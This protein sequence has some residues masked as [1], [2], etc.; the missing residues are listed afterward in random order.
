PPSTVEYRYSQP[1]RERLM[2]K[3][4]NPI[5]LNDRN[6]GTPRMCRLSPED[7]RHLAQLEDNFQL[8]RDYVGSVAA[9]SS[10]GL[11]LFGRG[12]IGKTHTVVKELKRLQVPYKAYN[13]RLTG[14]ALYNFFEASPGDVILLEDTKQLFR[15]SG[16]IGVLLSALGSSDA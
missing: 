4:G 12:G 9:A 8:I 3:N 5:D 10:T 7:Q 1:R 14:R 2:S 13:S 15:D 11:S 16:A 6:E